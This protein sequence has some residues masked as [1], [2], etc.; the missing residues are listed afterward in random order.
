MKH[1]GIH[2]YSIFWILLLSEICWGANFYKKGTQFQKLDAKI[3]QRQK[4][5]IIQ[6]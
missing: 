4:S 1:L 5:Q 2:A 6:H 3:I